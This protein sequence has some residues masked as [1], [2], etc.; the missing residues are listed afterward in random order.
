M[1]DPTIIKNFITEIE[2]D[3]LNKWCL[4]NYKN[5]KLFTDPNMGKK[6]TRLTTRFTPKNS[7]TFPDVAHKVRSKIIEHLGIE[8]SLIPPYKDGIACGIGFDSG[9][10]L[11]HKDPV[12]YPGTYTLHCNIISQKPTSG[13]ITIINGIEYETNET[14]LLC[15]PV[16]ELPHSVNEIQGNI[17]RILWVF[18]FAVPRTNKNK[19]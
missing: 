14:D 9:D 7:F 2:R 18:G 19:A 15:Y 12:W 16:S 10:I 17:E 11:E 1:I 13:G 3:E 4:D 5:S 6:G 8:N